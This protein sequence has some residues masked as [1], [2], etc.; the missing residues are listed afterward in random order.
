VAAH[1]LF[2][3]RAPD[4]SILV[5]GKAR[6]LDR[7]QLL[8]AAA[9][10]ELDLGRE[11]L[12]VLASCRSGERGSASAAAVLGF[13]SAFRD[14]GARGVLGALWLVE[15]RTTADFMIA[16]HRSF[17]SIGRPDAA[18]RAAQ[19]EFLRSSRSDRASPSAWA[20][21]TYSGT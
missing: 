12:V 11:A 16:F 14:A 8:N 21:Y 6:T 3:E 1:V 10:R 18:L 2:N 4:A 15:D 9:A 20:A 13:A 17:R 7:L 5:L 19:L